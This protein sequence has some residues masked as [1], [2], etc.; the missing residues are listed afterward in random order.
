MIVPW[1][2][3]MK[4]VLSMLKGSQAAD[5]EVDTH[6]KGWTDEW[7]LWLNIPFKLWE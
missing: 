3:P 4:V 2:V 7:I 6:T 1:Q 5:N